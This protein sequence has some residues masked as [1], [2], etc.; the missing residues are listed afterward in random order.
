VVLFSSRKGAA[1]LNMHFGLFSRPWVYTKRRFAGLFPPSQNNL[2]INT[3]YKQ[4]S[5]LIFFFLFISCASP[6]G[7]P[8]D[9][10]SIAVLANVG[11]SL[12]LVDVR[13]IAMI[14]TLFL[15]FIFFFTIRPHLAI[16]VLVMPLCEFGG[17]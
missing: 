17:V 8:D 5:F 16:A 13:G 10:Q 3:D 14:A 4:R 11:D 9:A 7:V 1:H 6:G 2:I 12:F 15:N